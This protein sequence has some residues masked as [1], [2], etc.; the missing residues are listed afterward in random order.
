MV[1]MITG[2]GGGGKGGGGG[3]SAVEADDSLRSRQFANVLDV[4]CEGEIEGIV[5]LNGPGTLEERLQ[6][7]EQNIYFDG[8]PLRNSTGVPNFD[9]GGISWA[10]VPGTQDQPML[11]VSGV[12]ASTVDVQQE[13]MN[14]NT[15]G[16]PVV[17]AVPE[18]YIDSCRVTLSVQR[19]TEQ[20]M[21]NGDLNGSRVEFAIDV[22]SNGAG[23]VQVLSGAIEGKTTSEYQRSYEVPLNGT[24]PWDVRVR[25]ITPNSTS[26]SINNQLYWSTLGKIT[27]EKLSYPNTAMIGLR[28][29]SALFNHVPTRAYKLRLMK[30]RIPS[31]YDPIARTYPDLWDG[32]FDYAWTDNPAWCWYDLA[33]STRYGLG[34][35]IDASSIDKWALYE[36]AKY[37]DE[38]VP[39]GR[40]GMEPRFTCNLVLQSRE[41]GLKV[42]M[43]LASIFR[44]I[45]Y[46]HS[47][48]VFCSQDRPGEPVKLFNSANVLDGMF[49]Y[50]GTAKQAR[51]T[52]ALV[53]WNDPDN[54]YQQ[55]VEYVE[56]Y[57]GIL[58]F[59]VRETEITAMGCTS[60]PQANRLG[61]HALITER[62]ETDTVTFRTGLEGF[63][64]MPG[65]IIQTSDP[66]RAGKRMGGRI[67]SSTTTQVTL[68]QDVT[69]AHGST[70]SLSVILPS[71]VVERKAVSFND[72]ATTTST[73]TLA[74]PLADVPQA[75][76]VWVLT[77]HNELEPELWRV[78]SI[79]E[80][81]GTV[82][83]TALEH[84]QGKYAAIEQGLKIE[85]RPT[86]G[87]KLVPGAVT[88]LKATNDVARL[89][90]LQYQSRIFMSWTPPKEGASRYY[91][92]WSRDND[93]ATT[94]SVIAP[95][96]NIDGVPA[97]TYTLSVVAE[98]AIGVR[99]QSVTITHVV[100]QS[101]VEPDVQNL[102]L[103]PNF[104]GQSCPVEWDR[105]DWAISYT[106]QVYAGATL[107]RE[108]TVETNR[109]TYTYTQNMVDGGP[110]RSLS[111]K[112]K[113][114][115]WR[116]N[117]A[118]WAV[119]NA[120]NPAP[121]APVGLSTEAGPGQVSI[122]AQRPIDEDLEGMIVWM[123]TDPSVTTSDGNRVYKG[124]DNAFMKTGLQAGMPVYF[125]VAFYD[126][127]GT[128][129]LNVS[130]SVSATPTA[131]GGITKVTALPAN[132]G[133][134][135]DQSAVFLDVTDVNVRGLYGWDGSAWKFTRDGGYLVANS[136]TANQ[137]SVN[138]LSA[139]SGNLGTMTAG[140]FTLDASGYI[141][142]GSTGY[143]TGNGIWMGY[144]SGA[145][146]M[147]V[148][149]P[150]G[151][152]FTWD[153]SNFIIRGAGGQILLASGSGV[154]WDQI[155]AR[156]TSLAGLDAGA[157]NKLDGIQAGA[158]VG[159]DSSNLKVGLS[160]NL[161]PN[162][163]FLNG[164]D[165]SVLG[166]NPGSCA[167][168]RL[169]VDDVYRPRGGQA[170][171]IFQDGH[172]GN[173]YNIGCDVYLSGPY[174]DYHF[175]IPVVTGRRYE[176]S[177]KLASHRADSLLA[178]GFFDK[179]NN[180]V[181]GVST[182][183]VAR[184]SGGPTFT[185]NPNG[186]GWTHACVFGYAPEYVPAQNGQPERLPAAY[187]SLYWRKS[188]TDVGA[189][190]SYAWLTQPFFGEALTAQTGPS[191]Y[192]PGNSYAALT[193]TW[194]GVVGAGKPENDATRG[195]TFGVD[196]NG[197]IT[198]GNA[199]TF[200]A[201][202]A[203]G[204]AQ[205]GSIALVGT[206][207]FSVKSGT[208]GARTEMDS[209]V[210]KVFDD[211]GVLRV[212]LGDLTV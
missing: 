116:G 49:T 11:P 34:E 78:I 94:F 32:T 40:G 3:R 178:I 140:N 109:Y 181:G 151:S 50:S 92:T 67:M 191:T 66:T 57:E 138:Q 179:D 136:V 5:G 15:G 43:N 141:R 194:S 156:P 186:S 149:S 106:V 4:L 157:G 74:E 210:I 82:E 91:V 36:I 72:V 70:Y 64:V 54:R 128:V 166:W 83:V 62:E 28:V 130:S 129:G 185:P 189:G 177:A 30:V 143:M 118:N 146:K 168:L 201:N 52:V 79:A 44:G 115:S 110:Y 90:D 71:G 111:F 27:K 100:D 8:V 19:L 147:H 63:G 187:A 31:G 202:A 2:A 12:V 161:L 29:D 208:V 204:A 114:R 33:S 127:F 65:E 174:A 199:S 144:H 26:S 16:G 73:L 165:P 184:N 87:I 171:E 163:E 20:N 188:D 112:V 196:I 76:S 35:Y 80:T 176:F 22:Q 46:W 183:W 180:Y 160:A 39:D 108:V 123:S 131:T 154:P 93:N 101:N 37:C 99:G 24:G 97:G 173:Q 21:S 113:A 122:M 195:A 38:L 172:S 81:D 14:G 95:T 7:A 167:P 198:Q 212:K 197:K 53:T 134:V 182:N 155:N 135:G 170:L 58:R 205:I 42:L 133:A 120:N 139:I 211:N 13:V 47:N 148:G 137:L 175:G 84:S 69:L 56:D 23:F 88:N 59:G 48:T 125:R 121:A 152:G 162:S 75:L 107:L 207:N 45:T 25:R 89:N 51:H 209:R 9:L 169:R 206:S 200:I 96:A 119:L 145:Y 18:L 86:S 153:G 192:S 190:D 158:T 126:T 164:F 124:K 142:G 203:I 10:F 159:A 104:S 61:L 60:R 117:S 55:A 6:A 77:A 150:T 103:A 132:P 1:H 193:S 102:R 98:N 68:D 41:E 105:L 17:R 85:P